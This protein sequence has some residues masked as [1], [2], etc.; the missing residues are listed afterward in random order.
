LG[1]MQAPPAT[2]RLEPFVR[3]DLCLV[4]MAPAVIDARGLR[5]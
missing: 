2:I 5:A 3:P 4:H 1:Q